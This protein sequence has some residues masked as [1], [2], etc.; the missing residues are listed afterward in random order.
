[1]ELTT[2]TN[3]EVQA[4]QPAP[5]HAGGGRGRAAEAQG[6]QRAVHRRGRPRLAGGA[7]SRRRRRRHASASS[8]STSSISATCSGR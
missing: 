1:M 4:L 3:D 2:L 5:H 6:G 8:I 7:V